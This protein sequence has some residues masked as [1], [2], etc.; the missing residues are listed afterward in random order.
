M[1]ASLREP[2]ELSR[3]RKRNRL[4]AACRTGLTLHHHDSIVPGREAL[5][6]DIAAVRAT[7][8]R[9]PHDGSG[10]ACCTGLVANVLS[11]V[12][13]AVRVARIQVESC[14]VGAVDIR[15]EPLIA[16]P[17]GI[18]RARRPRAGRESDLGVRIRLGLAR[19]RWIGLPVVEITYLY[20]S[21]A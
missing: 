13:S 21:S 1:R 14:W 12:Q 18:A 6:G 20:S 16:V 19:R 3:S 17:I 9:T 10:K 2:I 8:A 15:G 7:S 11:K 4:L 5:D